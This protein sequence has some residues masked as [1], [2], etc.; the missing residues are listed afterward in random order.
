MKKTK[1]AFLL[2]AFKTKYLQEAI[3]S[4]LNQTYKDFRLIIS[5]DCS[6]EDVRGIVDGFNDERITYLKNHK[7]IG[8]YNLVDHWNLELQRDSNDSE[9]IIM[10][11]DDDVYHPDFLEQI[12][13]LTK[14][15]PDVDL[16][17]GRC[18][19]G[20]SELVP[21]K[22]DDPADEYQTELHFASWVY[23]GR[24]INS[25]AN[26]VFKA[27]ALKAKGGFI[28][29]P[30]AWYSDVVTTLMMAEHGVAHTLYPVFTYRGSSLS[31]S[32]KRANRDVLKGKLE[33]ALMNHAWMDAFAGGLHYDDTKLNRHLYTELVVNF[34]H[35]SYATIVNYL[36][37]CSLS[38]KVRVYKTLQRQ[39]IF[40]KSTFWKEFII[41]YTAKILKK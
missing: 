36:R 10:A 37:V 40:G 3:A 23:N 41:H 20:D 14:K 9:Y 15:Y 8:G 11:S 30:Y 22:I 25:F 38:E 33:A 6:P 35:D 21:K 7:N 1:Y 28:K 12:D 17:R 4:I 27:D 32:S 13:E 39:S 18:V 19:D 29:F 5:D 24:H 2:A 31:I 26:F 16:L 34:R